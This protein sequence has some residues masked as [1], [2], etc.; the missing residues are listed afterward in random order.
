MPDQKSRINRRVYLCSVFEKN[1]F[2]VPRVQVLEFEVR[3]SPE[4]LVRAED[5]CASI[6]VQKLVNFLEETGQRPLGVVE[7][8]FPGIEWI[9]R[10]LRWVDP[11]LGGP[12]EYSSSVQKSSYKHPITRRHGRTNVDSVN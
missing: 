6:L 12:S 3:L 9:Y 4:E 7:N 11:A 5:H 10:A 2:F 8:N 1:L